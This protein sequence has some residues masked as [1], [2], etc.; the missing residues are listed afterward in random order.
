ML[1]RA[2]QQNKPEILATLAPK[3]TAYEN[4]I[5]DTLTMI[6]PDTLAL[7]HI[8]LLNAYEAVVYDIQ[9]MQLAFSD[10]LYALARIGIYPDDADA[11]ALAMKAISEVLNAHSI[12][13]TQDEPGAFFYIFDAV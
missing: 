3:Q 7:Q 6:V 13:Y 12:V 9:A 4:V 5:I 10:P 1:E 8:D 11:L 2:I